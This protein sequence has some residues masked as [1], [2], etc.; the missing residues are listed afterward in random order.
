MG[1][2]NAVQ[3][4][5]DSM[6]RNQKRGFS[7]KSARERTDNDQDAAKVYVVSQ[8]AAVKSRLDSGKIGV[9]GALAALGRVLSTLHEL[10]V[11]EDDPQMD[12]VLDAL[13]EAIL[14]AAA[15]GEEEE[16]EAE[17]T[18]PKVAKKARRN[19]IPGLDVVL[20]NATGGSS[21][22]DYDSGD[23]HRDFLGRRIKP[24]PADLRDPEEHGFPDLDDFG[25]ANEPMDDDD[26]A[27]EGRDGLGQ[28]IRPL[29]GRR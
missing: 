12:E 11:D 6:V 21:P 15:G 22:V 14:E 27:L 29:D 9:H 25:L 20:K 28:R 13:E 3:R 19:V 16:E 10:D 17:P 5:I 8:I 1:D 4:A 18:T 26:D 23:P 24:L 7:L 2:A